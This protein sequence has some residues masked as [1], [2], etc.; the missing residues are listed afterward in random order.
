[1]A[2]I[3]EHDKRKQEILERSL[4]VFC[5]QGYDDVTFQK[6]ADAC[7]ITRTTLYIYFKNKNEIFLW[8]IKHL[9]TKLERKLV[10]IINSQ[11]LPADEALRKILYEVTDSCNKYRQLFVVLLPYLIS[12]KKQGIDSNERV[13]R[14]VLKIKHF[15][16]MTIIEGQKSGVFKKDISVK[17]VNDLFYSQIE[18]A[19][20]RIAVLNQSDISDVKNLIDLSI[21]M[22]K[23]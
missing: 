6:I 15:M 17:D 9:T 2:V 12:L 13:R 18:T 5:A 11:N 14:R 23:A 1:M 7:G 10:N 4:E 8:S 16:S 21:R 20:F 22:I 3:V 19:I